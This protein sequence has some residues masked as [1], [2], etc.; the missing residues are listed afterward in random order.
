MGNKNF[1]NIITPRKMSKFVTTIAGFECETYHNRDSDVICHIILPEGHWIYKAKSA[2]LSSEDLMESLCQRY[3]EKY[4]EQRH[5]VTAS[6]KQF[7]LT[8]FHPP[9]EIEYHDLPSRTIGWTFYTNDLQK[10][11]RSFRKMVR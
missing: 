7:W 5:L 3:S 6:G 10:I 2:R 9:Q 4:E 11:L 8:D 1:E